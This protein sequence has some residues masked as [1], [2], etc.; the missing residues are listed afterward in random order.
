MNNEYTTPYELVYKEKPDLRNLF[1]MFSVG[2]VTK[3]RDGDVNRLNM[4]S[5]TIRAIA[6]GRSDESNCLVFY[7]PPTKQMFTSEDF[8]LDESLAA[9]PAFGLHYDGGLF[10]NKYVDNNEHFRPPTYAPDQRVFIHKGNSIIPSTILTIP[11]PHS[12]IYTVIYDTTKDIHQHDESEINTSDPTA[13]VHLKNPPLRSF[14]KWIQH[15]CAA[16]LFTPSMEK[17]RHGKLLKHSHNWF[18]R[19]GVKPSN[20]LIKLPDFETI[21]PDMVSCGHLARGHIKFQPL[22]NLCSGGTLRRIV[23]NHISAA[24]LTS[25]EVPTLLQHHSL[26]PEDKL[27]WDAAYKEEYDGL[28]SLPAFE[29]ITESDYLKMKSTKIKM[30]P[31][32]AISTI[33][34]NKDG[35]PQR[36]KYRIVAL[37]NLDPHEWT[38]S[39]VYAPVMSLLELRFLTALAVKNKRTLKNGDVKQAFVQATL[40]PDEKYILRPPAGCPRT[41][42]KTY[43]LLKRTLYG[44]K[45]SPKHWFDRATNLLQ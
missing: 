19:P 32:M 16:T 27:T 38:K 12:T 4:H 22:I 2:Y 20:K 17:L 21:A 36:A 39:D 1:P 28:K 15:E 11:E 43:W 10:I 6:V 18:F 23:A 8:R 31:T 40:P 42:P 14:P 44:L 26:P 25:L 37:G 3:L 7:H 33:K 13:P 29:C 24:N 41:P 35:L 34:F 5:K 30:L 45:R 9:G